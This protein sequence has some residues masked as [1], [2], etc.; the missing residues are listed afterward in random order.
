MDWN[1]HGSVWEID[2]I[3]PCDSFNML[4]F[5]QQKQCFHYTNTQPLFKKENRIKSNKIC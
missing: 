2:H 5:N 4:D 3:I 1:N